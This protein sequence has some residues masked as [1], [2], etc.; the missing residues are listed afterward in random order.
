MQNESLKLVRFEEKDGGSIIQ[1]N[2]IS[3]LPGTMAVKQKIRNIR[4]DK[5]P[6]SEKRDIIASTCR[7]HLEKYAQFAIDTSTPGAERLICLRTGDIYPIS[8]KSD[9]FEAFIFENYGLNSASG[10][11]NFFLSVLSHSCFTNIQV[12]VHKDFFYDR[13]AGILYIPVSHRKLVICTEKQVSELSNGSNGVFLKPSRSFSDFTYHGP[14]KSQE[15][16]YIFEYLFKDINCDNTTR[17]RLDQ[18]EAAFLLEIFFYFIPFADS[19]PTRPIL[20]L[21]GPKGSGKSSLLKQMGV[22]LFGP[23][24]RFIPHSKVSARA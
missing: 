13:D 20:I 22:A 18:E 23:E 5:I 2:Q 1:K 16:G 9:L 8:R 11:Y 19:M 21:H 24:F 10:E 12:S 3:V 4:A 6:A 15:G 17:W 14:A 7:D